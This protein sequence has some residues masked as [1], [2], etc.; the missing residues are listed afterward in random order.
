MKHQGTL[1]GWRRLKR[2]ENDATHIPGYNRGPERRKS[3]L[4]WPENVE[5]GKGST[6]CA[7]MM[8]Q[9]SFSDLEGHMVSL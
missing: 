6:D 2:G 7:V 8:R 5:W 3:L 4:E 1:P 9:S